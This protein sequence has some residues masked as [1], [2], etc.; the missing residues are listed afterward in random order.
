MWHSPSRKIRCLKSRN[1]ILSRQL[2]ASRVYQIDAS[3]VTRHWQGDV[4]KAQDTEDDKALSIGYSDPEDQI[5]HVECTN[6]ED[7][8]PES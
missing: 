6:F 3:N 2:W 5:G 8:T 4:W 1:I 7:G